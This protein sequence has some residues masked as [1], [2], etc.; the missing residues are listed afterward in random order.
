VDLYSKWV[1][2]EPL[3][4]ITEKAVIKFLRANIICRFR[5][6]RILISGNDTQFKGKEFKDFCDELHIEQ[7]FG[8]VGH[9][10]TNEQTE[11]TNKTLLHGFHTRV[12]ALRGSGV[13][14][15]PS[16]LWSFRT[17]LRAMTREIM[18]SLVYSSEVV[19]HA[20]IGLYSHMIEFIKEELNEQLRHKELNTVDERSCYWCFEEGDSR[21]GEVTSSLAGW[22]M[23]GGF[24]ILIPLLNWSFFL[25]FLLLVLWWRSV[26]SDHD[27]G[28]GGPSLLFVGAPD[29]LASSRW[30]FI[31]QE[32]GEGA[33]AE[34]DNWFGNPALAWSAISAR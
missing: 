30:R 12:K 32:A 25:F 1:E 10:T 29:S 28:A 31:G 27:G 15:L 3:A 18:F 13:D 6:P 20:N 22:S 23:T 26:I 5:V 9:P 7:R 4:T 16:V 21:A 33:I 24:P 34:A 17:T 2:V 8:S 11:N 19:L 14:E